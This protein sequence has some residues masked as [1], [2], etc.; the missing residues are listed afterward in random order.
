MA[1]IIKE[2]DIFFRCFLAE[3]GIPSLPARG[4][5]HHA[6]FRTSSGSHY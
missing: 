4:L 1:R 2:Q 3:A 5:T 6:R